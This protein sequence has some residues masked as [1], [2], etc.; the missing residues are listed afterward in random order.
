M[1]VCVCLCLSVCA[2][3]VVVVVV[4][5]CAWWLHVCR[6]CVCEDEVCHSVGFLLWSM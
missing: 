6:Q 4:D 2:C 1:C 3:V 5:V